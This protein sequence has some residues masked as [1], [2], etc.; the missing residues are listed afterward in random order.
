MNADVTPEPIKVLVV[1]DH[2][3][4]RRG[5]RAFLSM[6]PD[7]EIVGE[8]GNGQEALDRLAEA[9][10]YGRLPQVVLMDLVMPQ[11]DGVTCIRAVKES[12]PGV[13]TIA[14]TS[15]SETERVRAALAAG[16]AGYLLKEAEADEVAAAVRAAAGGKVHLD[17]SVARKITHALAGTSNELSSLSRREREVLTLVA[18]GLSNRDIASVLG[19]SERTARTH[20]SSI[21]VK[22]RLT[23]RTQAALWAI[24]QGLASAP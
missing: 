10:V 5:M 13:E 4:V 15:F 3:V 16:A 24:R 23:S 14:M 9:A 1:D 6:M 22:T 8:A 12:Y 18:E 21:L 19:I 2:A 7:F 20:V 11:M 17:P